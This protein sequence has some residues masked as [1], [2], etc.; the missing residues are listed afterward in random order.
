MNDPGPFG[1]DTDE[2]LSA[3]LDGE[4]AGFAAE[5]GLPEG[6]VRARLDAWSGS[7][8][9]RAA[10]AEAADRVGRDEPGDR[11]DPLT[12]R[13][14][15]RTAAAAGPRR[16]RLPAGPRAAAAAVVVVALGGL[17]A[18]AWLGS[19]PA[20]TG[21]TAARTATGA[22]ARAGTHLGAFGDLD[23]FTQAVVAHGVP[24]APGSSRTPTGPG[25]SNPSVG[26]DALAE[27]RALAFD[28]G[29]GRAPVAITTCAASVPGR[30][31]ATARDTGTSGRAFVA[32]VAEGRLL[33]YA[34]G[35]PS[36]RI[37]EVRS[38]GSGTAPGPGR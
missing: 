7:H 29:P 28:V 34:L 15:V 5:V 36:C 12:L 35:V 13:R 14:L 25:E 37:L 38:L 30:P 22:G 26:A 33:V 1:P 32:A 9:R 23:A 18:W 19:R 10:L 24:G 17:G 31:V 2:A 27:E 21:D 4:L 16:R 11:L 3:E 6:E 8:T 20:G